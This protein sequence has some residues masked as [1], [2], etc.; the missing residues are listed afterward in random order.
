VR[1]ATRIEFSWGSYVQFPEIEQL[2]SLS[3]RTTLLPQ[4]AI[5]YLAAFE[6]R[7]SERMRVRLEAYDRQDRDLLFRPTYDPRA[8]GGRIV[9]PP[10]YPAWENSQRGYARGFDVM[11]QRRTANGLTGWIAYGYGRSMIR[12]GILQLKFPADYDLRHSV[13]AFASYR[14]RPTVNVSGRA[15]YG[16][17]LPARGF[18]EYRDGAYF[19]AENRNQ[20][21]LPHYQRTDLRVNKMFVHD[22]WKLSLFGEVINVFNR[23]NLRFTDLDS[24]DSRTGAARLA[25]DRMF[26]ILPSAGLVV[27]F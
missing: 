15:V 14:L 3:G 26:P 21:R 10:L 11:L 12:G 17:G 23:R 27:E 20:V 25:I 18:Y 22:A 13:T 5:H 2:F 19:L 4:R 24:Y 7:L 6:H 8:A 9:N 1:A 16:S